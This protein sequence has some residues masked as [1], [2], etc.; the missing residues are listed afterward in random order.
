MALHFDLQVNGE[1]I[2]RFVA[3]R[4][5]PA[6]KDRANMYE[7]S[8][9]SVDGRVRHTTVTHHYG[10]GAWKLV[11]AALYALSQVPDEEGA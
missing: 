8:V 1:P 7:V 10:D 4:L 11:L 6:V 2:G 9:S 5:H 3:R